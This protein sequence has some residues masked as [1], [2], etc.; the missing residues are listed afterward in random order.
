MKV[1]FRDETY[2]E[3]Y[4]QNKDSKSLPTPKT[5]VLVTMKIYCLIH[6]SKGSGCD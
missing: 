5:C 3:S 6:W 1:K 2:P 4:A